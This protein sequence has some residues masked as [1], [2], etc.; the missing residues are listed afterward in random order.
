MGKLEGRVAI[1]TGGGQGIRKAIAKR[2]LK[3]G[4][5]VI[6]AEFDQETDEETR[7]N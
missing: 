4:M 6:I 5:Q 1:V 2:L 3:G 7:V